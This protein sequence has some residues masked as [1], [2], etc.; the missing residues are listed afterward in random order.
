[1]AHSSCSWKD[2]RGK[3]AVFHL[4]ELWF[5]SP[6]LWR[7][8]FPIHWLKIWSTVGSSKWIEDSNISI[9]LFKTASPKT[10]HWDIRTSTVLNISCFVIKFLSV[11][12][13]KWG[14][15]STSWHT[16]VSRSAIKSLTSLWQID[17]NSPFGQDRAWSTENVEPH[18]QWE[19]IREGSQPYRKQEHL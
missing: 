15:T 7:V 13:C 3:I 14:S 10:I 17:G 18:A 16:S 5:I 8:M 12:G 2:Q 11:S 1:M 9:A 4:S 19:G 6:I